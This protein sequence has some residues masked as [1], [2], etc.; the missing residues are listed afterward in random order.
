[1][2][3]RH[4]L[5]LACAAPAW[6]LLSAHSPYRQWAIFRQTHLVIITSRDDPA[7]DELGEACAAIVRAALPDSK[8][9]VGRGPRV[10]RIA[11]LMSTGQADV[12][13]AS[14]ANALDMFHGAD[15]FRDYGAIPLRVLVQSDTHQMI[16]REDFL[17]QHGYLLAEALVLNAAT[18]RLSVPRETPP[19]GIPTHD[20]ARAFAQGL[21]LEPPAPAA[22]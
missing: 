12:A 19:G 17:L 13:I 7:G 3:R 1:M 20:G 14:R 15:R 8:A 10:E 4:F 6:L 2:N 18:L 21:P 11:S 22:R 9:T 5:G 16:C